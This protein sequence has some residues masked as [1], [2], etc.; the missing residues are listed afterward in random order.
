MLD[1]VR[2]FAFWITSECPEEKKLF[3][4]YPVSQSVSA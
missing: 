2:T 4:R 3:W 1:S